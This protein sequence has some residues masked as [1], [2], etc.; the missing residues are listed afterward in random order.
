MFSLGLTLSWGALDVLNLA[1]GALMMFSAFT[2]YVVTQYVALPLWLLFVVGVGTA[3]VCTLLLDVVVFRHIRA[4]VADKRQAELLTLIA[5]V[6][7]AGIPV[8]LAIVYTHDSPFGI[9]HLDRSAYH[10]GDHAQISTVQ[11][12]IILAGALLCTA[13]ALWVSRSRTGRALRAVAYDGET[14]ELM[15]VN[16]RALSAMTMLI[17][18]SLAG[19]AGMLLVIYLGAL[20]PGSGEPFMLKGFAI[21]I[22][23]SVGSVWGTAIGAVVLAGTE[24]IVISQ[25]SGTWV[26][27]ISFA[28]ILLVIVLRPQGVVGKGLAE[29]V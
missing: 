9:G 21:I 2:A 29:R 24:T 18:G 16:T 1:H 27:A 5:G 7:A 22:L 23:G 19:L 6:G 8:T 20:T 15:G 17:A 12:V 14:S 28:I 11:A 10:L 26:D 13:L 3:G 4:R 25:T